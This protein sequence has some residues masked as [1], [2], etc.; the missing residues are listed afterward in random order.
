LDTALNLDIEVMKEIKLALPDGSERVYSEGVSVRDVISSWNSSLLATAVAS[1]FNQDLMDLS[2]SLHEDGV[3]TLIDIHSRE[4]LDILRHSISHVMAQ[5]VQDIFP[6]VLVSIGPAI[7]DGFYYDF[8][9]GNTFTLEDLEKIETRMQEIAAADYPFIRE[10]VSREEALR[11]RNLK[12]YLYFL[13][14]QVWG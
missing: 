6:G 5:A 7:E 9:Y 14:M 12:G 10:E 4:G 1:R 13:L 8:E 3:L 2:S 11:Y